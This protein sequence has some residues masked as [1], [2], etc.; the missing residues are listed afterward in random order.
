M[1]KSNNMN[2]EYDSSNKDIKEGYSG[3][4]INI[5]S[6]RAKVPER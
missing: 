1:N 3:D 6:I 4:F 5:T 2:Y